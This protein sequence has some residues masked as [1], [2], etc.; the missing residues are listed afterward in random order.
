MRAGQVARAYDPV[1]RSMDLVIAATGLVALA[2]LVLLVAGLIRLTSAGPVLYRARRAGRGGQPFDVLKLRTMV[3]GA[4]RLGAITVGG[5]PR[6]TRLGRVLR[7]TRLDE[8]PQL[9][10]ILRGEM[11]LVGPRPESLSIVEEHF[12][13]EH[14]EVLAL[15]PGLTSP[16]T[17]FYAVYQEHLRPPAEVGPEEFYIRCLLDAKMS[18]DLHYLAHRSLVYDIR[19]LWETGWVMAQKLL[20]LRPRWTPPIPLAGDDRDR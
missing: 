7:L 4:D 10:N 8:V 14:R 5:D 12:T 3:R 20:G 17:L 1:K 16:G 13:R 19:L 6:V 9:W 11:S 18:A 2:P 15:R